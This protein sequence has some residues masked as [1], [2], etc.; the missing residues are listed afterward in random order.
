MSLGYGNARDPRDHM[1]QL[2]DTHHPVLTEIQGL[3]KVGPHQLVNPLNAIVHVAKGSGLLAISPNLDLP[4]ADE[5]R[6]GHLAANGRGRLFPATLPG[7]KLT[8]D[9]MKARNPGLDPVVVAE[10]LA[11]ALADQFF[12]AVSV[13]RIRG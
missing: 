10:M 8:E 13:L 6:C 7:S 11:E 9:V 2:V 4:I 3:G 12:P 5:F 1:R